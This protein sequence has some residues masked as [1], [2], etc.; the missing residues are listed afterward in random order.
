MMA[1]EAGQI[2]SLEISLRRLF[3]TK[4]AVSGQ[5]LRATIER[6]IRK[7]VPV[8][9][10]LAGAYQHYTVVAGISEKRVILFDSCGYRWI[11]WRSC[12]ANSDPAQGRHQIPHYSV[13]V[14]K[15]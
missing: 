14:F 5:Q 15:I 9:I 1:E 4:D 12:W 8:L 13:S 10:E 6:N 3:R 7:G 2:L 11:A